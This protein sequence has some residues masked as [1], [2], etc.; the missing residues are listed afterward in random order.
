MTMWITNLAVA[1]A[2][3]LTAPTALPADQGT[4]DLPGPGG[5]GTLDAESFQ[6]NLP[7][8]WEEQDLSNRTYLSATPPDVRAHFLKPSA[9]GSGADV[10]FQ[11]TAD[12][13][14]EDPYTAREM[15]QILEEKRSGMAALPPEEQQYFVQDKGHGCLDGFQLVSEPE[16]MAMSGNPGL[17]RAFD[18]EYGC[19]NSGDPVR[20]WAWVAFSPDGRKHNIFLTAREDVWIRDFD[21]LQAVT[22]SIVLPQ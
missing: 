18:Y 7:L 11:Y 10:L 16:A 14:P 12:P 17:H 22:S 6:V 1:L 15:E 8:T 5:W 20:G 9:G 21:T 13:A 2:V 4:P 19:Y 3:A